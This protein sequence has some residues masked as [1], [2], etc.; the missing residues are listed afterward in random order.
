MV[1]ARST[2]SR[3][4][5]AKP[6]DQS[7]LPG[8]LIEVH[9]RRRRCSVPQYPGTS[10]VCRPNVRMNGHSWFL[11]TCDLKN[12]CKE[13]KS[14]VKAMD[15]KDDYTICISF[16]IVMKLWNEMKVFLYEIKL[17]LHIKCKRNS[18]V[19]A[20]SIWLQNAKWYLGILKQ[21]IYFQIY[22]DC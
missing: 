15:P 13:C 2:S 19:S 10:F 12:V 9:S 17:N 16:L 21:N 5:S 14:A 18:K 4:S 7:E 1:L 11:T 20:Y 3:K 8:R 22:V 6:T